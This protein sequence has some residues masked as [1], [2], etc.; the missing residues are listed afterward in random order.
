MLTLGY[1]VFLLCALI[2]SQALVA[3]SGRMLRLMRVVLKYCIAAS[4]G[5]AADFE[6]E[7]SHITSQKCGLV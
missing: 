2:S 4:T 3:G 6:F 1:L 7:A 5:A